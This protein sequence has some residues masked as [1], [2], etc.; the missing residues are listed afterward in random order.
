M[1]SLSTEIPVSIIGSDEYFE[2]LWN[3]AHINSIKNANEKTI[4]EDAPCDKN[5]LHSFF[6]YRTHADYHVWVC[7]LLS[8][9]G[10]DSFLDVL[11]E[12]AS[13][14]ANERFGPKPFGLVSPHV[15]EYRWTYKVISSFLIHFTYTEEDGTE[16]GLFEVILNTYVDGIII[17]CSRRVGD[18][19]LFQAFRVLV[20]ERS[21]INGLF[22][23]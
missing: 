17:E 23:F 15:K 8:I 22:S 19:M 9:Y 7:Y 3:S 18:S 11:N 1:T 12:K 16:S 4:K 6:K 20:N 5:P 13:Q 10:S 14:I 21:Q 2:Q